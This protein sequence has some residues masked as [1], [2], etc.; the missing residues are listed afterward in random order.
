M[1]M[2]ISQL[3]SHTGHVTLQTSPS[4]FLPVRA[5]IWLCIPSPAS[6]F[7]GT[8]RN[9]IFFLIAYPVRKFDWNQP[10]PDE[11]MT[12]RLTYRQTQGLPRACFFKK[13]G[14]KREPGN[15]EIPL[16]VKDSSIIPVRLELHSYRI[17]FHHFPFIE[18]FQSYAPEG[19]ELFVIYSK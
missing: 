13:P 3:T 1:H 16:K 17:P 19:T 14:Y 8:Q 18:E 7:L 15:V 6:S 10:I 11:S 5:F 9:C 4:S 2:L 12:E